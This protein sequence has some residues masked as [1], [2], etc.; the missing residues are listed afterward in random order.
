[1]EHDIKFYVIM[2]VLI[3]MSVASILTLNVVLIVSTISVSIVLV[4]FYKLY[5]IIESVIFK[6]TNF[7]QV[8]NDC[9][10]SGDRTAAIRRVKSG[11]C[12]TTAALIIGTPNGKIG[13]EEVENIISNSNC[14]FRLVMQVE[15][16]DTSKMLDRLQTKRSMIEIEIGKL[17]NDKS[18]DNTARI[19]DL[20]RKVTQIDYDIT[21]ISSSGAPLKVAQYITTS[22]VS[23]SRNS[24]Q[25]RA[26]SQ[27][28][29]LISEFGTL[30]GIKTSIL[31]GDD[32]LNILKFDSG[33]Y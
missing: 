17:T 6:R 11:F 31:E 28:R 33:V 3:L 21:G 9:E 2:I 25:E 22:Y 32:L 20:K 5:Y 19:S 4:S 27:I 1:M 24:A 15:K 14:T 18:K 23:A 10:V 30:I 13:Q 8:I 26:K 7:I 16:L 29:E 12:A